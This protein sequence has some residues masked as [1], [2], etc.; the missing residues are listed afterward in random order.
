MR[1]LRRS[2]SN[3]VCDL[4]RITD[5]SR[6]QSQM[7]SCWPN[8]TLANQ[9]MPA[10]IERSRSAGT[11]ASVA[12]WA[13]RRHPPMNVTGSVRQCPICHDVEVR[14]SRAVGTMERIRQWLGRARLYRCR[15]CGWRGW[16]PRHWAG[17]HGPGWPLNVVRTP[18]S[19]G[20]TQWSAPR[21]SRTP[22]IHGLHRRTSGAWQVSSRVRCWATW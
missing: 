5:D 15:S 13:T 14:R 21:R 1:R 18:I 16:G 10:K 7:R 9:L 3:T 19:Q 22:T 2:F 12:P 4:R 6:A 11:L 17:L 8:R 20:W